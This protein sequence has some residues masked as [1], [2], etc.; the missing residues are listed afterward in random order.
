MHPTALDVT[1]LLRL[2][3]VARPNYLEFRF[4]E[5]AFIEH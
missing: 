5:L 3:A 1:G 4:T 2:D